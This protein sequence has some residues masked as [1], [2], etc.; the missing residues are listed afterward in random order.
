MNWNS[1]VG[2]NGQNQSQSLESKGSR[3][4][5]A[6]QEKRREYLAEIQKSR[7]DGYLKDA[8]MLLMESRKT[9][10]TTKL[11]EKTSEPKV[12]TEEME[13]E[14]LAGQM[15]QMKPNKKKDDEIEEERKEGGAKKGKSK[16]DDRKMLNYFAKQ[17]TVPDYLISIPPHLHEDLWFAIP[18]PAGTR[19]LVFAGGY[20]TISRDKNGHILHKFTSYLPGG[21]QS[22]DHGK[23]TI[24]DAIYVEAQKT[25]YV[26]DIL[27]LKDNP[28]VH[29]STESRH[30]MMESFV[31]GDSK[32]KLA[33]RNL[34]NEYR[35]ILL[36]K[37]SCSVEV[38]QACYTENTPYVKDGILFYHKMA[39]YLSAFQGTNPYILHWKD[40]FTSMYPYETEA[41]EEV[42]EDVYAVLELSKTNELKT[43]DDIYLAKMDTELK[44]K[45][46][47]F[48]GNLIRVV[49][50]G[51]KINEMAEEIRDGVHIDKVEPLKKSSIKRACADSLSK[52]IFQYQMRSKPITYSELEQGVINNNKEKEEDANLL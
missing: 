26:L 17:L 20:K 52:I 45:L 22:A 51:I 21:W 16:Y 19:T 31:F 9:A 3:P 34:F 1:D 33:E 46:G 23:T 29:E 42:T 37:L 12:R 18:K 39:P 8:R 43:L 41:G 44:E 14:S 7:R 25:Y 32:E 2:V 10:E 5:F 48:T 27:Y 49:L 11:N 35:F 50:K 40:K 6:F 30:F 36:P 24:L 47:L 4:L 28:L 13:F 15:T 38:L